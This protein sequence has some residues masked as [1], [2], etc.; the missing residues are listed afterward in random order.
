MEALAAF[1]VA[2]NVLQV[3]E[4]S[5]NAVILCKQIYIQGSSIENQHV[6]ESSDDISRAARQQR[7]WIKTLQ[8]TKRPLNATESQLADVADKCICSAESL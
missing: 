2:C 6:R 1:G 7:S 4:F 3:I 5:K 8:S